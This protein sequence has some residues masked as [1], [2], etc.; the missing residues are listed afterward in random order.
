MICATVLSVN[1]QLK[2]P[3]PSPTSKL[4]QTVGLTNITVEYSRPG[5][6]DRTIFGDLVPYDKIWRTGA[7]KNTI[8]T[9]SSDASIDGER[10][11]AGSY[12]I[13]TKPGEKN[14]EVYFYST[15]DNGGLP[16]S[17][18]DANVVLKTLAKV[19]SIP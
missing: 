9:F 7:N 10:L 17:W 2:T 14:W 8:I 13:Y 5:V 1:A 16:K 4:E 18:K 11:K 6:K 12:A 15:I 3:K 19:E